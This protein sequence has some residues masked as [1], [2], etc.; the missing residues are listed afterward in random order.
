MHISLFW[1]RLDPS[2]ITC[3]TKNHIWTF[4]EFQIRLMLPALFMRNMSPKNPSLSK[5]KRAQLIYGA[6]HRSPKVSFV[7]SVIYKVDN[8]NIYYHK[9]CKRIFFLIIFVIRTLSVDGLSNYRLTVISEKALGEKQKKTLVPSRLFKAS[10]HRLA[11]YSG[12][13]WFQMVMTE[14]TCKQSQYYSTEI[15]LKVKSHGKMRVGEHEKK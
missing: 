11:A 5:V 14:A 6:T 2:Y 9:V 10:F 15:W 7:G 12:C 13:I 3:T 4:S 8:S 1:R